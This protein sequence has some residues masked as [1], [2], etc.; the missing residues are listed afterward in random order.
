[1]HMF[2]VQRQHFVNDLNDG[3]KMRIN[4]EIQKDAWVEYGMKC[5]LVLQK[6]VLRLDYSVLKRNLSLMIMGK[7]CHVF[8]AT[9]RFIRHL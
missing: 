1:M 8:L 2:E 3:L 9:A 6:Q 5:L 4:R 7:E